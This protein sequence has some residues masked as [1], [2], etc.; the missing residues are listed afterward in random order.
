MKTL[1]LSENLVEQ[2]NALAALPSQGF[3]WINASPEELDEVVAMINRLTEV[4]ID[5]NH[6]QDARSE[7]HPPYHDVGNGY[8]VM[9]FRHVL[10]IEDNLSFKTQPVV[11]FILDRLL[12]TLSHPEAMLTSIYEQICATKKRNFRSPEGLVHYILNKMTDQVLKIRPLITQQQLAWQ[13]SLLNRQKQFSDWEGLFAYKN[14]IS[15]LAFLCEVQQDAVESW[16]QSMEEE[17]LNR[18]AVRL[19]DLKNHI[20]RMLHF[21]K[22]SEDEIGTLMQLHYALVSNRTN[23]IMRLL[24]V[25]SVIF[26]PLSFLTGVFGMNFINMPILHW[27]SGFHATLIFMALTALTL[28]IFFKI[29]KW[30]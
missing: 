14:N 15:Q 3:I 13:K 10:P 7:E 4:S 30:V 20:S 28:M 18:L 26:M 16:A 19:N 25:I 17:T 24:A 8:E 23:N 22:K 11:F 6:L 12:V 27:N 1:Y 21:T 5:D 9:I 29:K 2:L